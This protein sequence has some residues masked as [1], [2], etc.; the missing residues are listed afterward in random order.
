LLNKQKAAQNGILTKA[1][2]Q[3]KILGFRLKT[4]MTAATTFA[5]NVYFPIQNSISTIGIIGYLRFTPST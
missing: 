2:I 5:L 1:G 4:G 3:Y